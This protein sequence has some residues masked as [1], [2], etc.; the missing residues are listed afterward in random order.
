MI[1]NSTDP[2]IQYEN[3]KVYSPSDDTFLIVDYFRKAVTNAS[4]DGYNIKKVNYILDMGTGTGIIAIFLQMLASQLSS[5]NPKIYASD[6]LKEAIF[7]AK[8]NEKINNF[9]GEIRF[10][11]SDLFKSF[12]KKLKHKFNVIIF[13][14][15][16]LP[17]LE[18]KTNKTSTD[19]DY[20][21][22]G[23]EE[24]NETILLFFNQVVPFLNPDHNAICLLYFITSSRVK[25]DNI[26]KTL[27][28]LGFETNIIAKKHLFFE[29]IILNRA[30]RISY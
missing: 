19:I 24:G 22:N 21:W 15:P 29:D 14:P 30:V 2:I 13:N 25:R 5:L 23:G 6:I 12:P 3:E 28:K 7:C 16:Y 8:N 27:L 18:I 9:K 20:S 4:F 26:S 11:H 10:I 1:N 17:A